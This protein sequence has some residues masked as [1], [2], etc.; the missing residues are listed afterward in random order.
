MPAQ[1]RPRSLDHVALWVDE[2][3]PLAAFLCDHLGMHVIEETRHLHA[4]RNRRQARQA[5]PVRRRG[6]APA[7]R[8][9][10]GG[11]ARGRPRRGGRLAAVRGRAA[12]RRRGAPSRRPPACRSGSWSARGA[13]STSTTSSCALRDPE[14]AADAASR[15]SASS[16]ARTA[17]WPWATATCAWRAAAPPTA[18]ARCSTTS[19]CWWTPRDEIQHE[20]E[21]AGVEIDDVK[22]AANTF[23]V[24]LR[25]PRGRAR[26]VRRA[27]AGLRARLSA[28]RI[29]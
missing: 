2:R 29:D 8:A 28:A 15:S 4:R 23:A 14:A 11:A 25:G 10:A 22:D 1:L 18:G 9:R 3:E 5:D 26:R 27:Q 7:R 17:A 6:P 16:G 20:A 24:F 12:R 13:T 19:R 21:G